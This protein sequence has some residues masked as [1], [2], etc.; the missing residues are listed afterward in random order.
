M[1]Q[2][3]LFCMM[4]TALLLLSALCFPVAAEYAGFEAIEENP[5]VAEAN[6][7]RFNLKV[8]TEKPEKMGF[9]LNFDVDPNGNLAVLY[10]NSHFGPEFSIAVCSSTGEF[11][12]GFDF[13]SYWGAVVKWAGADICICTT[14]AGQGLHFYDAN[15]NFKGRV[16]YDPKNETNQQILTDIRK[17]EKTVN[18]IIYRE[19]TTFVRSVVTATDAQGNCVELYN[20]GYNVLVKNILT[21]L[22]FLLAIIAALFFV[23]I[24]ATKQLI[25]VIKEPSNPKE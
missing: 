18:G 24:P 5:E 23:L 7:K 19:K 11:Q 17:N 9:V 1:K 12:Y 6:R 16:S 14:G 21:H 25:A 20:S 10:T 15:G 22:L 3:R 4:I 13:T 8:H 2:I